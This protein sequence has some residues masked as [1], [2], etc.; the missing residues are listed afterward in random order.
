MYTNSKTE[1]HTT[2]LGELTKN[3]YISELTI[4]IFI[5]FE[6]NSKTLII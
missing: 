4:N 2:E 5:L 1:T 3:S 6:K